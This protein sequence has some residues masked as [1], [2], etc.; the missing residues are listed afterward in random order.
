MLAEVDELLVVAIENHFLDLSVK[1]TSPV[2]TEAYILDVFPINL[3]PGCGRYCRW[4]LS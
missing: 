1:I 4:Q 2:I 3:S